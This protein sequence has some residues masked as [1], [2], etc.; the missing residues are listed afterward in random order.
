MLQRIM[1]FDPTSFVYKKFELCEMQSEDM[2]YAAARLFESS[3]GPA[4]Y[5]NECNAEMMT[6]YEHPG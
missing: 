1:E 3:W 2:M 6:K 4:R 5:I